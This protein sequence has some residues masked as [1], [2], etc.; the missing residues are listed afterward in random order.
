M[1]HVSSDPVF[2]LLITEVQARGGAA[3]VLPA[4]PTLA[5]VT[6]R[7][8]KGLIHFLI[9]PLHF[10]FSYCGNQTIKRRKFKNNCLYGKIRR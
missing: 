3:I 7:K 8:P 6:S 5:T 4:F 1:G 10:T 2:L 9:F